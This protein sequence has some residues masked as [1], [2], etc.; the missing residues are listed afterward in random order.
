MS[1]SYRILMITY[2]T[3]YNEFDDRLYRV[4]DVH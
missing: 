2:H 3:H 1:E 4:S